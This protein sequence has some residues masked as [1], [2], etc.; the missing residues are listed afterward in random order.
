[1]SLLESVR[2]SDVSREIGICLELDSVAFRLLAERGD[3]ACLWG[4]GGEGGG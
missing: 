3:G 4:R 2:G 1:M